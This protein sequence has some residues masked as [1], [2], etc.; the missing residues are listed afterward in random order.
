MGHVALEGITNTD[1]R[2]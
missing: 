1:R 2:K